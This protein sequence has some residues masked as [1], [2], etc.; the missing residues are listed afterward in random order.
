MNG[1]GQGAVLV[2]RIN[3]RVRKV[4]GETN[5]FNSGIITYRLAQKE[6]NLYVKIL[7]RG[8]RKAWDVDGY[9]RYQEGILFDG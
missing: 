7:S 3:V 1:F 8:T 6:D 9:I 2:V 5:I 4:D